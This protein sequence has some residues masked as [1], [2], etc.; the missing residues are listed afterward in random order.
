MRMRSFRLKL[1]ISGVLIAAVF[2][3]LPFV[4]LTSEEEDDTSGVII[5][6][7][8][9]D[10]VWSELTFSEEDDGFDALELACDVNRFPL[11]Y[12]DEE[13]TKV[14]SVNG[15]INLVGM[16]WGM[17]VLDG[18]S[19]SPIEVPSEVSA[20]EAGLICWA[21]APDAAHV[22][23]GT[24]QTGFTYY[25]Y[26]KDGKS[27][28]TGLDLKVVSLAPSVTEMLC[29]VGGL[30]LIIGTDVYSDYPYEVAERRASGDISAVGGYTDPNFEWIVK[31]QP[32]LVFCDG[33]TG[34]HIAMAN[35]LRKSGIDCVVTYDTQDV[36]T[37][38]D[39][40]WILASAIGMSSNANGVIN[41]ER[42][43]IDNVTGVVGTQ[44]VQRVFV[45][46]GITSSPWTSGSGTFMSDLVS[47]AGGRN[48]FDGDKSNWFMVSKEQI[49]SKQPQVI[50]VIMDSRNL[51]SEEEYLE[52]LDHL[53]PLWK[54][55]PAYRDGNVFVFSGEAADTLSRPGPRLT[56]AD[57]LIA[58]AMYPAQ[59]Q[60]LDP[61]DVAPKWFGDD[62]RD[63]LTK[64]DVVA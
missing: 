64:Q 51:D 25:D 50:I 3:L 27:Q 12:V 21:R 38:Y 30:D 2:M 56:E 33:G 39:N 55:T 45:S 9:W 29:S 37:V 6:F 59:F 7:G 62:Y 63:Y 19:W 11:S 35:K 13:K 41:S 36:E 52:V 14:S 32:D 48:V 18:G 58:K 61:L 26:A 1:L 16:E 23:P 49:H 40:Q 10:I 34:E 20:S 57:E 44:A 42:N 5:D 60:E 31:L 54:E 24:D 28:K 22:I 17:Y 46:L 8:Y 4:G 43:S 53:D 15:Q 47:K